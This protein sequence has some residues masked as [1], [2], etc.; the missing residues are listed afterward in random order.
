[1]KKS[2]YELMLTVYEKQRRGERLFKNEKRWKKNY[3]K[4]R[5]ESVSD[6][7]GIKVTRYKP[8]W[9]KSKVM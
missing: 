6:V 4:S 3:N 9:Q 5:E 2:S 1:M 8:A 7:D